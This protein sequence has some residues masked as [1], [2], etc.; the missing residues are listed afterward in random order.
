MLILDEVQ[1]GY[2]R[3]GRFFAHQQSGIRP[4]LITVAKG[5]GNGFPIGGVLISPA[6]PSRHGLLGTTFGG[7]HLACAAALA[8]LEVIDEEKLMANADAVGAHLRDALTGASGIAEV[9]G[10]GL[11]LGVELDRPAAPIRAALLR[12]HRVF[13]GSSSDSRTIRLLPPLCATPQD[14][15][16]VIN[17]LHTELAQEP[18]S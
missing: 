11:M 15:D 6:F 8:V 18:V 7:N 14:A 3:T 17:A 2:G 4:D 16:F 10:R 9:R 12:A 1:S 13:T 5:M